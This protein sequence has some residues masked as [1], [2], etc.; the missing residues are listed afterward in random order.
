MSHVH[1]YFLKL[2][3]A[4]LE[5]CCPCLL[6]MPCWENVFCAFLSCMNFPTTNCFCGHCEIAHCCIFLYFCIAG[7]SHGSH[8]FN[9]LYFYVPVHIGDWCTISMFSG[10]KGMRMWLGQFAKK[11]GFLLVCWFYG[12]NVKISLYMSLA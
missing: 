3:T 11:I 7:C 12:V 1:C 8:C 10:G 4:F 6:C 5:Q 2:C 9:L